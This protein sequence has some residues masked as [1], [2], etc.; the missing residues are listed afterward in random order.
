[1]SLINKMLQDLE[2]RRVD[3]DAV[4]AL[5]GQVR[6]A[7]EPGKI[8]VAWWLVL[9]LTLI[10]TGVISWLWG[11]R[12]APT[13][14]SGEQVPQLA[15]KLAPN[16]QMSQTHL[17]KMHSAEE[18]AGGAPLVAT[19]SVP[20]IKDNSTDNGMD[21]SADNRGQVDAASAQSATVAKQA[22]AATASVVAAPAVAAASIAAAPVPVST[23]P[24]APVA[25]AS[26]ARAAASKPI[27]AATEK[28]GTTD[29]SL[30][31]PDKGTE[32]DIPANVA[33]QIKEITPHQRA[34]EEYRRATVLL[35]QGKNSES[36]AALERALQLDPQHSVAR[37]TLAGLLLEAKRPD[38]AI[39][40]LQNGLNVDKN[41]PALAMMLA[42]LQVDKGELRP[43]VETLQRTL[44]YAVERADYQAFLA[45]LL[46]RE[47]RHKEA[48]EH[49]LLALRKSPQNG[50]WWM[51]IAIS[52]QADNRLGEARDAFGRAKA[53]NNLSPELLAFVD[54][55]L[56]QLR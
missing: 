12:T 16:I 10:L 30:Q 47:S 55:R 27:T 48:S 34:E 6:A 53:S 29:R 38:E 35:D 49:Y 45:A 41:H 17:P 51:G 44:P 43:A 50:L 33:K 32:F 25:E 21:A 2:G 31:K 22:S 14:A 26:P 23:A 9:G 40:K 54:E 18:T 8:H 24:Q 3:G 1:M 11:Y 42:R 56:N 36:M 19:T 39:R 37:Q 5:H 20:I 13:P 52:L 7:P 46:Q 15:L 28:N 4:G